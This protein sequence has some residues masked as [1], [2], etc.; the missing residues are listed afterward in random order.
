MS[1]RIGKMTEYI[2]REA[3]LNFEMDIEANPEDIQAISTGMSMYA[4][5]IKTIPAADVAPVK[6]MSE[7]ISP[8]EQMPEPFQRVI[9][10]RIY[11]RGEPLRVEQGMWTNGW[12]KVYGANVRKVSYWMPMPEPPDIQ[13]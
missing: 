1:A 6:H 2:D 12:W 9:V 4:E 5:Y 11:E 7:W 8:E 3:A 10:A 13:A